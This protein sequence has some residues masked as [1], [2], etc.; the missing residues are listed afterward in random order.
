[1]TSGSTHVGESAPYLL[2]D[3]NVWLDYYI[4][5]RSGHDT[6]MA[7]LKTACAND[8]GLYYAVH[9]SK[10]LFF[11]ISA[12]LKRDARAQAGGELSESAANAATEAA[13]GCIEHLSQIA[14]AIGCDISDVWVAAKQKQLHSDYEDDLMIAAA[15]RAH[16]LLV[17]GDERLVRHSPVATMTAPD[18]L[19]YL[20]G[21]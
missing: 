1:M 9:S 2:L 21:F 11:L 6:A 3:T 16:A 4:G 15:M 5:T 17:T 14:T 7:L 12:G 10:D 8:V 13:W 20:E 19:T 18:A